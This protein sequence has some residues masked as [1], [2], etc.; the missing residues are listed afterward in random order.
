MRPCL[1]RLLQ[2]LPVPGRRDGSGHEPLPRPDLTQ[3]QRAKLTE[4]FGLDK[5]LG[6]QFVAYLKETATLNL[7]RS[8]TTNQPVWEEIKDKA[9]PT[10]ALVGVSGGPL[11][12]LRDHARRRRGVAKTDEGRLLDHGLHDGDLLDAGSGSG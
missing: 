12:G 7:G 2:L 6:A 5:S 10:I 3:T 4:E 1:R 11:G 9:G 8:Y